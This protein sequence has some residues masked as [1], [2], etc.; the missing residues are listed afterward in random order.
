MANTEWLPNVQ[1]RH[2][3]PTCAVYIDDCEEW[4]LSICRS[5]V[6]EHWLHGFDSHQPLAFSLSSIF[7]SKYL[8][9]YYFNMRQEF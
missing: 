5:S 8:N 1:L 2:F 3:N 6:A 4:W 9:S 7:A